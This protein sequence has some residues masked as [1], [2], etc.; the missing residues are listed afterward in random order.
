MFDRH[1][2][3]TKNGANQNENCYTFLQYDLFTGNGGH[4]DEN[5]YTFLQYDRLY[6]QR[7]TSR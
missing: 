1:Y 4:Q 2:S 3:E 5:C 7:R 6:R